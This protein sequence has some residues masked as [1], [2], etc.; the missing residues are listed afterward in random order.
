MINQNLENDLDFLTNNRVIQIELYPYSGGGL[1]EINCKTYSYN[2]L[3][4]LILDCIE[5][6]K[7]FELVFV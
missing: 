1:V 5:L 3:T 4:D 7:R 2:S 6:S